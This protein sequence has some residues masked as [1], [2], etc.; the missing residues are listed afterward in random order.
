MPSLKTRF[1]TMASQDGQQ[2]EAGGSWDAATGT[3][4]RTALA[5]FTGIASLSASNPPTQAEVQAVI[6]ELEAVSDY[7][8]TL[9]EHFV[10]LVNDLIARGGL[11]GS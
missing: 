10:P 4:D 7:L 2:S 3:E 1:D 11:K 6:A 8:L 9:S 5:A